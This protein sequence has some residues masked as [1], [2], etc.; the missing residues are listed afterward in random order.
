[1][2]VEQRAINVSA[3]TARLWTVKEQGLP[4]PLVSHSSSDALDKVEAKKRLQKR[5]QT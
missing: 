2:G 3:E 1:V 5:V 4:N